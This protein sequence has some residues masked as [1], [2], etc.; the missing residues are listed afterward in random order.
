VA[1]S[2]KISYERPEHLAASVDLAVADCEDAPSSE[3]PTLA[4]YAGNKVID[5]KPY[6]A[7]SDHFDNQQTQSNSYANTAT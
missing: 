5:F 7:A 6:W 1:L 4:V 2:I 3:R